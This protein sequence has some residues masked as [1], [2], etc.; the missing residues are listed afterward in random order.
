[1]E[2]FIDIHSHLLPGVDDGSESMEQTIR[3]LKLA[4]EEGIRA[5]IAT[6]HW[7]DGRNM[8]SIKELEERLTKVKEEVREILPDFSLYLGSE[9]YYSHESMKYLQE[10]RTPTLAGTK[11]VLVEF[12]PISDYRYIKNALQEIIME[13]YYPVIAHIER[14]EALGK[15]LDLVEEVIEMG[16][17][18]QINAMS[19]LGE[20]GRVY[21]NITK[22]LLKNNLVHMIATDAHSDKGRAP[23]LKKCYSY[24][25]KKYGIEYAME[26]MV[27]NQVKLLENQVI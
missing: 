26:L 5:I 14:Y 21:Q 22:K 24:V 25:A 20:S 16:A 17:Y 8:H 9:I 3:I 6:P 13:G 7:K 27:E 19:I 15:K 4:Y 2:G 18:C 23:R 10:H 1:M 12:S 11:Y